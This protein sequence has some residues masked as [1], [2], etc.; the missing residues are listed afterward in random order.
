MDQQTLLRLAKRELGLSYRELAA[1]IG[2]SPRTIEKWS[3]DARSPD[4]REMPLIATRFISRLLE[5]RKRTRVLAGDRDTAEAVD[6]IVSHVSTE[7]L[8]DVL[9]T[10]DMLQRSAGA[11][12][13]MRVA[14][15]KPRYF[16]TMADKNA[17]NEEEELD[18]ARRLRKA[19]ASAR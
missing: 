1:E 13:P 4:H 5:D 17:W 19:R 12:V 15:D 6:A 2:V 11:L 14:A 7:K 3:L 9:R 10:F 16:K 8:G 18:N